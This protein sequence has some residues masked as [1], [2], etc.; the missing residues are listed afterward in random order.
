MA[1]TSLLA[2]DGGG[3]SL[4]GSAWQAAY[5]YYGHDADGVSYADEVL[6]RAIGWSQHGFCINCSV[7]PALVAAVHDAYGL[8]ALAALAAP[9]PTLAAPKQKRAVKPDPVESQPRA[10]IASVGHGRHGPSSAR[11]ADG[12]GAD[13]RDADASP[14]AASGDRPLD[15]IGI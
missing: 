2:S 8:S 9:S 10:V 15:G 12:R 14:R 5:D 4:D 3:M 7:D 1:A 6:A 11:A 13:V